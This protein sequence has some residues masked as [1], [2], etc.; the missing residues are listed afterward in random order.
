MSLTDDEVVSILKNVKQPT[1]ELGPKRHPN[2]DKVKIAAKSDSGAD[3][4]VDAPD[5]EVL[6]A[7]L[8]GDFISHLKGGTNA[9]HAYRAL[10]EA[11]APKK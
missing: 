4:L 8:A 10:A 7:D 2:G 11:H 5:T 6:Y 3:I 9:V 1:G